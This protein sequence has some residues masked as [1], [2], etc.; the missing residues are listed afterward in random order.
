MTDADDKFPIKSNFPSREVI[1]SR[2][3]GND[4]SEEHRNLGYF[5][6]VHGGE[7]LSSPCFQK[8]QVFGLDGIFICQQRGN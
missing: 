2:G 1:F 6:C 8:K 4:R 5:Y 7:S 3:R